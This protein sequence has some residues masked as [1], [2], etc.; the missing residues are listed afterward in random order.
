[1]FFS[2]NHLNLLR[3]ES[4]VLSL[5]EIIHSTFNKRILLQ[6]IR[7]FNRNEPLIKRNNEQTRS[8]Q[9]CFREWWH[10]RGAVNDRQ[11]SALQHWT[12][13]KRKISSDIE[14][15]TWLWTVCQSKSGASNNVSNRNGQMTNSAYWLTHDFLFR[16]ADTLIHLLKGSLGTGILAMPHAFHNAGYVVG[17]ISTIIIGILCTYCVHMILR[18]HYELC[19]RKQVRNRRF[20]EDSSLI[21][22]SNFHNADSVYELSK[23]CWSSAD[24]RSCLDQMHCALYFVSLFEPLEGDSFSI[25][26]PTNE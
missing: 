11:Q 20:T 26:S 22:I 12:V 7:S 10:Q 8:Q 5:K 13:G 15:E 21:L 2:R 24:G 3:R 1:M 6:R 14:R 19:K 16:N 17:T 23:D 4:T 25:F 18:A 9:H